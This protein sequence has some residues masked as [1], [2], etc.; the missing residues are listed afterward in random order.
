MGRKNSVFIAT[1]ID[2]YIADKDGGIDWLHAIPNPDKI[3]MGYS[4]FIAQVD[5]LVMGRKTF[6]TVCN[7]GIDWPYQKPVFVLSNT[8]STISEKFQGRATLVKGTIHEVLEQLY[9]KGF[10]KLYID[11]GKTI[12]SFL[13]EDLID[14]MVITIIP[15]LLGG[16]IP[17]FS[18]LPKSLAFECVESKVYL[19]KISQNHFVR[20]R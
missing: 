4:A 3:D 2:G 6:E 5:A 13:Q 14:E 11:G 20:V 18:E 7:F 17:L 19:G 8:L 15:V 12:Q 1:S 16:G 10:S 9:Q